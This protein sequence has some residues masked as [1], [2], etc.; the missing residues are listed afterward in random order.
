ME[1]CGTGVVGTEPVGVLGTDG[2]GV[3]GTS[4]VGVLGPVVLEWWGVVLVVAGMMWTSVS[5]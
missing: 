1:T 4:P 2:T 3:V 5:G